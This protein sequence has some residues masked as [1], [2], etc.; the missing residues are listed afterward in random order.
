MH[1]RV[2]VRSWKMSSPGAR[3]VRGT[4]L[5]DSYA[6]DTI[7]G[8]NAVWDW[9]W[10]KQHYRDPSVMR[11]VLKIP[12]VAAQRDRVGE[13]D[14]VGTRGESARDAYRPVG[15]VRAV[16]QLRPDVSSYPP[17]SLHRPSLIAKLKAI[18]TDSE[19][20]F[21]AIYRA[22]SLETFES[23]SKSR[24]EITRDLWTSA[25]S[26]NPSVFHRP[27]NSSRSSFRAGGE[28]KCGECGNLSESR[29][30]RPR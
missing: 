13:L 9:V 7:A 4:G 30:L 12:V 10:E 2:F 18:S 3:F 16:T 29:R 8:V 17:I 21:D 24:R 15:E 11:I 26:V 5:F 25:S 6:D 19:L 14:R 22:R 1:D 23:L 28:E 20:E 27:R